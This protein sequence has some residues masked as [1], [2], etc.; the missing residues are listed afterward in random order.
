M[1]KILFFIIV[2]ISLLIINNLARSIYNLWQ[3]QD[4]ITKTE[5]KLQQE[6]KDNNTLK[7]QFQ[8]VKQP[9]FLEE[10]ARNKLFFVKPGEQIVLVPKN[11]I[12]TETAQ[13]KLKRVEPIW[14]QW[15]ALFF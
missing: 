15:Y 13:E 4:L 1:R 11:L 5:E 12:A 3:K 8:A 2:V 6:K 10:Q 9:D 14:K 7:E